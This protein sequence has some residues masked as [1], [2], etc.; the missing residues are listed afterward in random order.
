MKKKILKIVLLVMVIGGIYGGYKLHE[1]NKVPQTRLTAGSYYPGMAPDAHHHYIQLPIDHNDPS[2]GSFTDF[3]YLSPNFKAGDP[4]IFWL[5]DNQQEAVGMLTRPEHFD[6]FEENLEGLSYVLIG[7]RGVSPTLF[8][9]VF[10]SDGSVNYA[11]A[12]NLYGSNQ[13]VEDIEAIRQDMQRQGLLPSDGKIMLYGGSGG[14]VLEQQFLN[15]YGEHV[16]RVLIE[17]SGGPDLARQHG[18]TFITR[19]YKSNPRV[20]EAYFSCLHD[21]GS[22]PDLAFMLFK[23]GLQG[24]T[25]LQT[26]LMTSQTESATWNEIYAYLKTWLKP[27]YNYELISYLMNLPS[28]VEVKVRVYEVLGAD[29][30]QYQPASAQ[31]LVLGY[32]WAADLLAD[33]IKAGRAGI[34]AP[35]DFN[36]DR[37]GYKGEVLIWAGNNDQDFGAQMGRWLAEAYPNSKLALFNDAHAR[38]AYP[39]YY[40]G[41][42]KVFFQTGLYSEETQAYFQDARQL[43]K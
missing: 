8:P 34:I 13:Q 36:L 21:A 20:A 2:L 4:V 17:S 16:T 30:D 19:T 35:P 37:S 11:R 41:F 12:M 39:E 5:F 9:E 29:L 6:Y 15:K 28:E 7:N 24:Q 27:E 3:Y 38:T 1:L 14:G 25:Q 22:K 40:S 18:E 33:F 10:N 31:D 23:V 43:S 26:S 42:R 32:E